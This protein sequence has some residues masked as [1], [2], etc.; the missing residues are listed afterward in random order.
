MNAA[1]VLALFAPAADPALDTNARVER[2]LEWLAKHQKEDGSWEGGNGQSATMA[3]ARAGLA[4]LMQG[5]T[6]STGK[7]APQL[8][9][10]VAWFEGRA[11]ANGQLLGRETN[12]AGNITTLHAHVLVF[13]VSAADTEGDPVRA[14][15]LSARIEKGVK[16]L[17]DHQSARGGWAQSADLFRAGR[18][19]GL[20]TS[21]ALTALFV[22]RKAGFGVPRR[23]TD[24]GLAYLADATAADGSVGYLPRSGVRAPQGG[25]IPDVTVTAAA[26]ALVG[27]DPRPTELAGWVRSARRELG[28]YEGNLAVSNYYYLQLT[29][30]YARVARALGESGH[31]RLDSTATAPRVVW[32]VERARLFAVVGKLQRPDGSWA[33]QYGSPVYTSALAL[34]I[35]QLDNGYLPAFTP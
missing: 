17:L 35:L 12:D 11:Q 3:T 9:K 27:G 24:R 10:A 5:S 15:A 28:A 16:F 29:L 31:E 7:Y 26:L 4:L 34:C 30:G 20:N 14:K 19:D 13:L 32:S 25:G 8:R 21:E 6:T 2:G 23:A 1:L 18:D 22:A 33:D